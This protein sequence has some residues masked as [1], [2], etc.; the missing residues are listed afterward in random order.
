ML[1]RGAVGEAGEAAVVLDDG[2]PL[3][4][5]VAQEELL[6]RA[7]G[8]QRGRD[9][10]RLGVHDVGDRDALELLGEGALRERAAGRGG[11]QPAERGE[12]DAVDH[13]VA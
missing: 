5:L 10:D 3:P 6:V 11:E 7:R 8:G 1:H 2:E 9:R 13:R 4:A 12:P